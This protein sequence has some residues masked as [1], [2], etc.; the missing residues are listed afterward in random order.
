[1]ATSDE[2]CERLYDEILRTL[3][4]YSRGDS[5]IAPGHLLRLAK[6]YAWVRSPDEPY[7]SSSES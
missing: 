2:V 5:A 7:G 4:K 1:M 3:E 6:A